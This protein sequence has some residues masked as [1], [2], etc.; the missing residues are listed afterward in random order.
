MST[1]VFAFVGSKGGCG[2]TSLMLSVA[3]LLRQK[4]GTVTVVDGDFSGRRSVAVLLGA[5]RALDSADGAMP[6][7]S[8]AVQKDLTVIELAPTIDASFT[9]R[10]SDVEELAASVVQTSSYVL[11]DAPQPFAASIRPLISRAARLFLIV[12][13]TMLGVTG[14]RAMQVEIARFGVAPSII[15]LVLNHRDLRPDISRSE[16]ERLLGTPLFAEIPNRTDRRYERTVAA[17]ADAL[18]AIEGTDS[19]L[20]LRPSSRV[21]LGDRRGPRRGPED[22]SRTAAPSAASNGAANAAPDA[23]PNPKPTEPW[24]PSAASQGEWRAQRDA[25]KNDLNAALSE[26]L[27]SLPNIA[28]ARSDVARLAELKREVTE[29]VEGLLRERKDLGSAEDVAWLREEIVNEAVGLGPLE[30]LLADPEVTEIM[31]NGPEQIFV[32]RRGLIERTTKKFSDGAQL[33]TIIERIITPLGRRVDESS[34]MVDARLPDGSRVNAIIEPLALDGAT[35]TI[36]RFGRYRLQVADL[37]RLGAATQPMMNFIRAAVEARMNIVISGGTGSGKT[38]FLNVVSCFIPTRERI[39]TIEDAAE[40]RLVQ[41]HVVRLEARPPNI[42]GA[43]Q[44][45]IHDLVRNA[46]RM[47]PDRIVVGEC[48]GGEAL[49]M[50][51]AMNTG[52]DGSLTT[53]HA[54]SQRDA[55]SRIETLVM[56]AGFDLPIRA[57]REQIR[58][59]VDIIIQ[60]ARLR[61]GSRKVMAI[62]EVIGME[63][64]VVTMQDIMKFDEQGVDKDGKVKGEFVFSGVRPNCLARFE[65]LGI[66]Y[67]MRELSGLGPLA[68]AAGW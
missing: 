12:E 6:I 13:P 41:S 23:T 45:T 54:N 44:V 5:V 7:N 62:A 9:L 26:R 35:M 36:R 37:V 46:L 30:D 56:M 64:D 29:L 48:R 55:I 67:D 14:A 4:G 53:V 32:E 21:P 47:R 33:R 61:D 31:V 8:T 16:L 49:D 34:P 66:E 58:S 19:L 60:T 17:F 20:A 51:Q 3:E 57:I 59:A 11:V 42:Q 50:L 52:H 25:I 15:G 43:G 18:A 2:A 39:I 10:Q 22:P 40:L 38:T 24:V 65:E 68:A 27:Q 1:P 28:G 63:G